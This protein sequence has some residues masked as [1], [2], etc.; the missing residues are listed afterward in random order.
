MGINPAPKLDAPMYLA[1]QLL[2]WLSDCLQCLPEYRKSEQTANI[3]VDVCNLF[4]DTFRPDT[5]RF[6]LLNL[7][8][9]LLVLYRTIT[10]TQF[11]LH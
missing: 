2:L 1:W 10:H 3:Y 5:P 6:S 11:A 7:Q 9:P 8:H 4:G